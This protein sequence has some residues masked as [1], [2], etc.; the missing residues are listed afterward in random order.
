M[1]LLEFRRPEGEAIFCQGPESSKEGCIRAAIIR[2]QGRRGHLEQRHRQGQGPLGKA[3][4]LQA[5]L[6]SKPRYVL[7]TTKVPGE[8]GGEIGPA[9]LPRSYL[10][11]ACASIDCA[12]RRDGIS[13]P[14]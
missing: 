2:A 7:P 4:S 13:S 8:L 14:D 11:P 9:S 10:L 12:E 1:I 6:S 5:P 3:R